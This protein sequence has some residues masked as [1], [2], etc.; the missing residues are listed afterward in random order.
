[1]NRAFL[2]SAFCA[3][4]LLDAVVAVE[5]IPGRP[6]RRRRAR[7][8]TSALSALA[9][10]ATSSAPTARTSA[11]RR[12]RSARRTWASDGAAHLAVAASRLGPV[13]PGRAR[14]FG[15]RCRSSPR[16]LVSRHRT[17]RRLSGPRTR[18]CPGRS[19]RTTHADACGPR[20]RTARRTAAARSPGRSRGRPRGRGR[21]VSLAARRAY[22]AA[23]ANC[24]GPGHAPR[25]RPRRPG[26]TRS[27]RPIASASSALTNRPVKIRSLALLGPDQPGQPLGAA[28]AG[29]DAEQDLGLAER[30]RRRPRSGRRRT[31]RARSR[32]RA[33]SR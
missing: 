15:R 32:R 25:R 12:R 29:D 23:P 11:R 18:P 31:A 10:S 19:R 28:G 1:M 24:C 26:T 9:S 20:W 22:D 5:K 27:T 16:G 2:S 21:C 13:L 33:R 4:E 8:F 6:R 30:R 7:S 3:G 17:A 14:V